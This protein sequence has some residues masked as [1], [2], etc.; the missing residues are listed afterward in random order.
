MLERKPV[1]NHKNKN[2]QTP[3]LIAS[4]NGYVDIAKVILD[5][6]KTLRNIEFS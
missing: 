6:G 3:L 2:T 4:Q 5:A 1:V